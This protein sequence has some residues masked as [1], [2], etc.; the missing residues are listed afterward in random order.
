MEKIFAGHS[1]LLQFDAGIDLSAMSTKEIKYRKPDGTAGAWAATL[2]GTTVLEKQVTDEF[3]QLG[4]W[5]LQGFASAGSTSWIGDEVK[6]HIVK[7]PTI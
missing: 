4:V 1:K 7:R 6:V 2:N 3:N 5:H